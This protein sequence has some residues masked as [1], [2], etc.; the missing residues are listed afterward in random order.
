[1]AI[2]DTNI[3]KRIA[4]NREAEAT[5]PKEKQYLCK[6]FLGKKYDEVKRGIFATPKTE[7]E[8]ILEIN[9]RLHLTGERP[10]SSIAKEGIVE[11][12]RSHLERFPI[13]DLVYSVKDAYESTAQRI[14][15][16]MAYGMNCEVFSM[17]YGVDI[18]VNAPDAI[19]EAAHTQEVVELPAAVNITL[20]R[21]AA[22]DQARLIDEQGGT[23]DKIVTDKTAEKATTGQQP[24]KTHGHKAHQHGDRG[25]RG[26]GNRGQHHEQRTRP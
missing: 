10:E 11:T 17:K 5:W 23:V 19:R 1:M 9:F 13:E 8:L 16:L 14:V 15:F 6:Y 21:N 7:A 3:G 2:V 26:Q 12:L 22:G 4:R 25:Q 20:S 24:N 18:N